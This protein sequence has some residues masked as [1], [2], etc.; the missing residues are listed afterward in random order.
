MKNKLLILLIALTTFNCY[1]QISYEKGYYIDNSDQKIECL[2]KNNDWRYNPTQFN[3]KLSE[4]SEAIK[5]DITSVKE[6]S[7]YDVSKYSRYTVKIDRS[8]ENLNSLSNDRHPKFQEEQLF[9]KVLIEGEANLFLYE[10]S[11]LLRFFY[12]TESTNVEQLVFKSYLKSWKTF[13]RFLKGRK[14]SD[15]VVGKNNQFKQQ[16]W[17]NL[18]CSSINLR[19]IENLDYQ[20]KSLVNFFIKYNTCNSF[21]VIHYDKQPKRD[22][23]NLTF[24][25]RIYSSSA[26]VENNNYSYPLFIDFGSVTSF[27]FGI[28]AEF[29]LP[30]NKNKWAI[31]FE[32]AYNSFKSETAVTH[33]T[34]VSSI[35]LN[36]IINYVF[37]EVPI[38][39]RHYLFLNDNSKIFANISYIIE[40]SS[41]SSNVEFKR[42]DDTIFTSLDIRSHNVFSFGLGYKYNDKYSIEARFSPSRTLENS[43]WDSEYKTASIIFGYSFF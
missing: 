32:A 30:V 40:F 3:Y 34:V 35:E 1:S 25:P 13:N 15:D 29:I 18:K 6:F 9:L 2:I 27:G 16:L 38:S 7:I 37:V 17:N 19:E 42:M 11:N 22:L 33:R 28:E 23:F 8:S 41:N 31:V 39:L 14:N 26:T 21:D 36:A 4:N 43:T 5:I 20:K 24:R 12:S 10:D